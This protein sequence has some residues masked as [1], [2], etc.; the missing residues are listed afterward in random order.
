MTAHPKIDP[1]NGD[2]ISFGYSAGGPLTAD[3]RLHVIDRDGKLRRFE[4][5]MAPFPSMVHDFVVTQ[6]HI[7]FPIFPLT[8]SMERAK[9]GL[10]AYAWEPDRGTHVGIMP[11]NG[12]VADLRWFQGDP[13]YVYHPMNAFD[14]PDGAVVCDMVKHPHAPLLPSRMTA[15]PVAAREPEPQLVR[16]TFDMNGAGSGFRE[17]VLSDAVGEFPRLDDRFA[18]LPYRHGFLTV[19]ET[20]AGRRR[21]GLTHV[22]VTTGQQSTWMPGVGDHCGEPVFVERSIDAAEGDGWILSV[23]YRS[24]TRTSDLAVFDA[25][26]LAG[27]PIGRALLSHHVPMGF[28]GSWVPN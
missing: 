23:I 11:R 8:G 2:M 20:T 6:S 10:P 18:T 14:A 12:T 1:V 16:W 13:S 15:E 5:F 28:H 4:H 22:D 24:E 27:G 26:D 3:M 9:R 21:G 17:K 7:I 19:S 25:G